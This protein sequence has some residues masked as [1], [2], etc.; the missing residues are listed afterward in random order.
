[1]MGTFSIVGQD[2]SAA[3]KQRRN[4]NAAPMPEATGQ[5]VGPRPDLP[6]GQEGHPAPKD[7]SVTEPDL[8]EV[9]RPIGAAGHTPP[10]FIRKR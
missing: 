1:M 6:Q 10:P 5:D 8:S 2:P 9:I 7:W 3:D 4:R